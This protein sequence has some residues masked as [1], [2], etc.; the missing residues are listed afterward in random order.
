MFAAHFESGAKIPKELTDKIRAAANF[1]AG[2]FGMRQV[3]LGLLDMAWHSAD[4][5]IINDIEEFEKKTGERTRLLPRV[6]GMVASTS[7]SHI[8]A[9]GY[10]SGYYSYKWAEVLDADAFELFKERGLFD[11]ATAASFRDNILSRGG[12]EHPMELYKRFR[13]REP[14]ADALLRRSGLLES[15]TKAGTV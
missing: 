10:S 11:E 5:S 14:D 8:F 6:A 15:K 1:Q 2:Y 3:Q 13:G 12:T 7:F 9:G 4:P